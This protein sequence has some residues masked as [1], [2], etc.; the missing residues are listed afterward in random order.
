[1]LRN[2][3]VNRC[4]GNGRSFVI[5]M[6]LNALNS[7]VLCQKI[8]DVTKYFKL[9]ISWNSIAS[10]FDYVVSKEIENTFLAKEFIAYSLESSLSQYLGSTPQR[11]I[12]YLLTM[13]Q[14]FSLAL[15]GYCIT[16]IPQKGL[17]KNLPIQCALME[18]I[19]LIMYFKD[20]LIK[21]FVFIQFMGKVFYIA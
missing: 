11:L 8:S 5:P 15:R 6:A 21:H 9:Y 7:W 4:N 19:Y 20:I 18:C 13:S 16:Q 17:R 2:V 3:H 1:M 14:T 10:S 12:K